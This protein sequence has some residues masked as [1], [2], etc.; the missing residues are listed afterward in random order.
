ME[1]GREVIFISNIDNLGAT[2]D[3]GEYTLVLTEFTFCESLA[4]YIITKWYMDVQKGNKR[5]KSLGLTD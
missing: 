1:E 5:R 3:V 2:V 4:K